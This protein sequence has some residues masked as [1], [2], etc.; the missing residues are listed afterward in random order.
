MYLSKVCHIFCWLQICGGEVPH[1]QIAILQPT[2]P[3]TFKLL[4]LI[5]PNCKK[6]ICP[7][8]V[9]YFAGCKS[10]GVVYKEKYHTCRY[11]YCSR[12]HLT[13]LKPADRGCSGSAQPARDGSLQGIS[14]GSTFLP[15]PR[16][17]S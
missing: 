1:M 7:K 16:G 8:C 9:T 17:N 10:V 11:R 6:R 2:R 14:N 5:C 15:T 12:R 4:H 3:D 13:R